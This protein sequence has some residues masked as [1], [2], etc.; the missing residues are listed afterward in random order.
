MSRLNEAP[1]GGVASA[2]AISE[3]DE[4][5]VVDIEPR[6]G[7]QRLGLS[8]VWAYRHLLWFYVLRTIRGR[9]RPTLLGRGWI[10]LRPML[11][12]LV[13]VLVFGLL[14]RVS[15]SPIPFVAFV[16]TGIMVFQFFSG[17]VVETGNSL[18][19][20]YSIMSKVYYPRLIV[21]LTAVLTNAVD[22]LATLPVVA[23]LMVIY[24]I[25]PPWPAVLLA[26][27]FLLA[28]T[29]VTLAVGVIVA[30]LAVRVRDVL[31]GLPVIMRVVIY[32]MPVAYP[33][34]LI[35]DR[36]KPLYWLNPMS[37]YLQGFRW[38]VLGDSAPPLWAMSFVTVATVILLVVGLY[39]FARV[40]RTMVDM[41]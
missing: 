26:P 1:N 36:L 33:V 11:L 27:L 29:V 2:A 10:V 23:L 9:Y 21:P 25:V 31:V 15:T 19:S 8:D 38:A 41:L 13:Y 35:P 32:S 7:L 5:P 4:W 37:T 30:A 22:F 34:S 16:F 39:Y 6:T 12:S 20:N 17:G 3:S 28:I 14:L 40:E 24:R 18:V